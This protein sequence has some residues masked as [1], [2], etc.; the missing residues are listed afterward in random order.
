MDFPG[1]FS[2]RK[3]V[4]P[5]LLAAL[6]FAAALPVAAQVPNVSRPRAAE[7]IRPVVADCVPHLP[8]INQPIEI[9]AV[10]RAAADRDFSL[11]L[12]TSGQGDNSIPWDA[13]AFKAF[14]ACLSRALDL[15]DPNQR[16]AW[17]ITS[18]RISSRA[19]G[20][21][22]SVRADV[23]D[24]GLRAAPPMPALP[25]TFRASA[26]RC[27]QFIG[28][29]MPQSELHLAY[30]SLPD[31]WQLRRWSV[32]GPD[33]GTLDGRESFQLHA[34]CMTGALGIVHML[35]EATWADG[36]VTAQSR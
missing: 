27:M 20:L 18:S 21:D 22:A 16:G 8:P 31:G 29:V 32:R 28:G 4:S 30:L 24:S 11:D 23:D 5:G 6:T 13:P 26:V 1:R 36:V 35:S 25:E 14:A 17:L 9:V 3:T 19:P 10:L 7:P 33:P 2:L 12:R 15:P 34:R